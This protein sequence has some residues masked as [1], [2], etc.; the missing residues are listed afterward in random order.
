M[1]VLT[2]TTN[3][4][5]VLLWYYCP[6]IL[7]VWSWVPNVSHV[8]TPTLD[9]GH[10]WHQV[11]S[12][13]SVTLIIISSDHLSQKT[14]FPQI[15]PSSTLVPGDQWPQWPVLPWCWCG[16]RHCRHQ[17][18]WVSEHS[19][20][21]RSNFILQQPTHWHGP[22]TWDLGVSW[23]GNWL[24]CWWWV[25]ISPKNGFYIVTPFNVNRTCDKQ[26]NLRSNN[27]ILVSN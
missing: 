16:A 14:T 17:W 26:N 4:L 11:T 5:H 24:Y 6:S 22:L 10:S 3:I 18:E 13:S 19:S 2:M 25:S 7:P 27:T 23:A 20:R 12:V 1:F 8:P 15:R 21:N 9:T